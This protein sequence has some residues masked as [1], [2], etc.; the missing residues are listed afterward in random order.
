MEAL[1]KSTELMIVGMGLT[2]S[3]LAVLVFVMILL[4]KFVE[5]FP[6]ALPTAGAQNNIKAKIALAIAAARQTA[7]GG[8]K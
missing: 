2:F 3:F 4:R 6:G 5:R 8:Q 1:L 7:S